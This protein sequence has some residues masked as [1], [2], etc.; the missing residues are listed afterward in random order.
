LCVDYR[1]LNENTIRDSYP[2]P[3]IKELFDRLRKAK[4]FT[5]LDLK[6]AYNLVRIREG[7]E[8]KTAFRTRYGHF[9]YLV[10]PFGLKNAPAT[11]QHFI[12]DVL[13]EYL[14]EFA[15]SYIDDI[16][17]YSENIEEHREHVKNVLKKLQEHGLYVKL[18]K[19]EFE[20]NETTFLGHIIS[21]KGI[22][23]DP[24]KVSAIMDWPTPKNVTEIQ[25]FLGLRNYYCNELNSYNHQVVIGSSIT[26]NLHNKFNNN[27]LWFNNFI[28]FIY[29]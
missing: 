21:D 28:L 13:G 22:S 23:M 25:S 2:L 5:K 10:M 26:N 27:Y 1:R 3:L 24:S 6:S 14:D 18:S 20:T 12:N 7:D 17:I 29:Y 8:Y 11:F 9:E 19:C 15:F 4:S 16:L